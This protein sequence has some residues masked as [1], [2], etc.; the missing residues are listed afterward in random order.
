MFDKLYPIQK[1]RSLKLSSFH[2]YA[3]T[4]QQIKRNKSIHNVPMVLNKNI[5]K[6]NNVWDKV[7]KIT[8]LHEMC[9]KSSCSV[10]TKKSDTNLSIHA[11]TK[12]L[13]NLITCTLMVYLLNG[14]TE[15]LQYFDAKAPCMCL[16][17]HLH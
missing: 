2:F 15:N 11:A 4:L 10:V 17:T 13:H 3:Y 14:D 6:N 5:Y 1:K 7:F 8:W 9:F 12:T 16:L